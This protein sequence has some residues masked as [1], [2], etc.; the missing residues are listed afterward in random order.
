MTGGN[1]RL[2]DG[3][4]HPSYQDF[5]ND[6][7]VVRRRGHVHAIREMMLGQLPT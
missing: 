5:L 2:A 7:N 3:E 1:A 6:L 4:R